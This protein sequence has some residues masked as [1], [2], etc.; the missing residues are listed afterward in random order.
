[1]P[2]IVEYSAY[3]GNWLA[4]P[5]L[6]VYLAILLIVGIWIFVEI[7]A[8]VKKIFTVFKEI[9]SLKNTSDVRLACY[10]ITVVCRGFKKSWTRSLTTAFEFC[11]IKTSVPGADPGSID[12]SSRYGQI[13]PLNSFLKKFNINISFRTSFPFR[14]MMNIWILTALSVI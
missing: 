4:F 8:F 6:C 1:M 2:S 13:F 5:N 7:T 11:E 12:R 14:K 9:Y 10:L 3:T